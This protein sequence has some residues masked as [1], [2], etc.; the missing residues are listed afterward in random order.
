MQIG[1]CTLEEESRCNVLYDGAPLSKSALAP[2]SGKGGFGP[3]LW[4]TAGD[5]GGG[6]G[7]G[8]KRTKDPILAREKE[9]RCKTRR[10]GK[11][12]DNAFRIHIGFIKL[13]S[14]SDLT[15]FV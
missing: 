1:N 15:S 3:L 5:R 10:E 7:G 9:R 12:G 2:M 11:G 6:G 14:V 8:G 4:G 13:L